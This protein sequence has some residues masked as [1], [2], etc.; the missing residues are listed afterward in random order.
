MTL[1]ETITAYELYHLPS[2]LGIQQVESVIHHHLETKAGLGKLLT[3]AEVKL[4][5]STI[6]APTEMLCLG[7]RAVDTEIVVPWPVKLSLLPTAGH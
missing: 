7:Y 6:Y 2:L 5:A 4:G 3:A 1:G